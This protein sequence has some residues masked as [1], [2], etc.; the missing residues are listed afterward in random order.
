MIDA[1]SLGENFTF[2]ATTDVDDQVNR[3]TLT[4]DGTTSTEMVTPYALFGDI[5]GDFR[6]GLDLEAGT[7]DLE[8]SAFG[9][10]DTLL[11]TTTLNFEIA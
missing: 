4:F 5:E 11:E 1:D 10:D 2:Y 8:I 9:H 6:D 3:V 7:Y